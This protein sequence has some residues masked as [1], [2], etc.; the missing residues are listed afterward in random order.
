MHQKKERKSKRG[1]TENCE[2]WKMQKKREKRKMKSLSINALR[3]CF[4]HFFSKLY[5]LFFLT[6]FSFFL[7]LYLQVSNKFGTFNLHTHL[8]HFLLKFLVSSCWGFCG[9]PRSN[10]DLE[11]DA[12]RSQAVPVRPFASFI[13]QCAA[14]TQSSGLSNLPMFVAKN[15]K[16][17]PP[18][19]T[20]QKHPK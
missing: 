10:L 4:I 7:F 17:K 3:L 2:K 12:G 16:K 6:S 8:A 11:I 14:R 5:K 18:Q 19:K 20:P 9:P 13:C 15:T 1:K